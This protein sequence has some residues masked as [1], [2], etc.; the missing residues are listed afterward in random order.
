MKGP[1]VT[2]KDTFAAQRYGVLDT[3][4]RFNQKNNMI[5]Q[6][7]WKPELSN[8]SMK[9]WKQNRI[10]KIE[11]NIMGFSPLDWAFYRA[12]TTNS[13][14]L[15]FIDNVP[16]KGGTSWKTLDRVTFGNEVVQLPSWDDNPQHTSRALKKVAL[17]SGADDVG[18]CELNRKWVYSHYFDRESKEA[19]PIHFSD[20]T[21]F[22]GITEPCMLD[23][24]TQVIP[25]SMKYA[26]VF[27]HEMDYEGIA[28]APTLNHMATTMMAYS[29]ISF[30]ALSMAEFIRSLGYNA[31]PS[32]NC[33]AINIPLAI[34]AGL[35]ELARS[36][37]LVHPVY[38]PR[39]RISKVITDMPLVADQPISFGVKAFCDVCKKCARVCPSKAIPLGDRSY[40]TAGDFSNPGVLQWQIDHASC[41]EYWVSTGTNCGLCIYACPYNKPKGM[42]HDVVKT[43]I[44]TAPIFNP[45]I[46][47][48]DDAMG[49][50]KPVPAKNFWNK[51]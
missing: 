1:F 34:D 51:N 23:D 14:A 31:I 2:R 27:I 33:T 35:G 50:G 26:L 13:N 46:V 17:L 16:N 41:R 22:S 30:T 9:K 49:H 42:V 47:K 39:C 48:M 7:E 4:Q 37:K 28:T 36:A 40:E 15:N 32:A 5:Y 45:L 18:I 24:K 44:S 10:N 19:Y 25:A 38:G 29:K 20:E 3:Y 6:G 21:G 43:V 12:A 11:K 8:L